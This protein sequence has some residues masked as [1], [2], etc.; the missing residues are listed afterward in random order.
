MSCS[1]IAQASASKGSGRR[2]TRSHG[3]RRTDG[4]MSGSRRK[5]SWNARRSS[6]TPS[7]KRMRSIASVAVSRSPARAPNRTSS[8]AVCATRTTTGSPSTW[9]RRSSTPPR[10]RRTPSGAPPGRRNAQRGRTVTRT[11]GIGRLDAMPAGGRVGRSFPHVGDA[12]WVAPH[13]ARRPGFQRR[14]TAAPR[15]YGGGRRGSARVATRVGGAGRA[16]AGGA[17]LPLVAA[18]RGLTCRLVGRTGE[19]VP[20]SGR[21]AAGAQ[22]ASHRTIV[23]AAAAAGAALAACLAYAASTVAWSHRGRCLV[24]DP[25][26]D[27]ENETAQA[28]AY[29]AEE[30][31]VVALALAVVLGV[32]AY[33][34]RRRRHARARHAGP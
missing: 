33:A 24:G 22:R 6:S 4:P 25:I 20:P 21:R 15:G 2:M 27:C 13:A 19:P 17:R 34:F 8:A 16:G 14:R 1:V 23:Y 3:R 7:A 5:R 32:V 26:P 12:S 10:R 18:A 11:S 29:L 9:I 31:A 28:V 30:L